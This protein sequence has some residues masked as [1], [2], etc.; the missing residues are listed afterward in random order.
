[1]FL[2]SSL[3]LTGHVFNPYC[4]I[5]KK[6]RVLKAQS[7]KVGMMYCI[8]KIIDLWDSMNLCNKTGKSLHFIAY[9]VLSYLTQ[10]MKAYGVSR[11]AKEIAYYGCFETT[12]LDS[13]V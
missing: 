11:Y 4:D 7:Y 1:M 10:E 3:N 13:V 9:Y 2:G 6:K 5:K 8:T 12:S